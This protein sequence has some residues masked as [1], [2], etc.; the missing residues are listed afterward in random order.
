MSKI[1][2]LANNYE[3]HLSV[4]W[5]PSVTG[6]QKITLCIYDKEDER[7]LR[8]KLG[9]F[10]IRTRNTQHDWVHLDCT[11]I[12]SDWLAQ[13]DYCDAYFESPDDIAMKIEGEFKDHV[14]ELTRKTVSQAN[15]QT[16]VALS[17][18]ASLYGFLH[19]SELIRAVEADINGRLVVFFPG[20]KDG[21]N[22][23]L[24][25]ARDGWNYLANSITAHSTGGAA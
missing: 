4:P 7:S 12:F 18:V 6:A 11:N 21:S 2:D 25:D 19:L 24:L 22:Y 15:D 13:D 16:V 8:A 23:R 10:E 9:D 5:Q 20:S 14:I 1:D 17:G 3:R